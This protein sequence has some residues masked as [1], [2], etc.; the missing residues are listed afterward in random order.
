[1]DEVR[2]LRDLC[3]QKHSALI[4]TWETGQVLPVAQIEALPTIQPET[5]TE[6]TT[7]NRQQALPVAIFTQV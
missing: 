4:H 5:K 1:M 6:N 7:Q 2:A 3:G